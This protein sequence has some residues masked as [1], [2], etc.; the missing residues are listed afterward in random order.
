[1]AQVYLQSKLFAKD[2]QEITNFAA[3]EGTRDMANMGNVGTEGKHPGNRQ[4]DLLC[5]L[6]KG[7]CLPPMYYAN[8]PIW[9]KRKKQQ[10]N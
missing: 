3:V 6:Q 1:M 4:R 7:S 2:T 9:N 5:Y 8:I 10:L